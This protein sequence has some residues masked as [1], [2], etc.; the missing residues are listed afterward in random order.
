MGR[1]HSAH[2]PG[3]GSWRVSAA[4]RGSR[5]HQL[6]AAPQ[7]CVPQSRPPAPGLY[8]E[9]GWG[10]FEELMQLHEVRAPLKRGVWT[11]TRSQSERCGQ[12]GAWCR[13]RDPRCREPPPSPTR[14]RNG[15]RPQ[16]PVLLTPDPG[17]R[18][19]GWKRGVFRS[20]SPL[21]WPSVWQP[22]GPQRLGHAESEGLSLSPRALACIRVGRWRNRLQVTPDVYPHQPGGLTH[23]AICFVT[24]SPE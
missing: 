13:A 11:Q 5:C 19:S 8:L 23:L 10:F 2:P 22:Q 21:C 3:G 14:S 17:L 6:S 1:A 4:G 16:G 7:I 9:T 24:S 15:P 18:P 12:V 20:V